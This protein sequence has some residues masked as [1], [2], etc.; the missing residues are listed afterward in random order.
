[1]CSKSC[2]ITIAKSGDAKWGEGSPFQGEMD[3]RDQ[4][5]KRFDQWWSLKEGVIRVRQNF[6]NEKIG[7]FEKESHLE[8]CE[9]KCREKWSFMKIKQRCLGQVHKH[10]WNDINNK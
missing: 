3:D 7:V 2:S 4:E 8:I 5:A 9:F 10:V 1:M 6:T